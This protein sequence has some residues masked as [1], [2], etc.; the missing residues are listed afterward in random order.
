MREREKKKTC[1]SSLVPD[2]S[3]LEGLYNSARAGK[4]RKGEGPACHLVIL[5]FT[6]PCV[7]SGGGDGGSGGSLVSG[8]DPSIFSLSNGILSLHLPRCQE[9]ALWS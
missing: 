5:S 9:N 4:E 6:I 3:F 2:A 8:P 7:G 1:S